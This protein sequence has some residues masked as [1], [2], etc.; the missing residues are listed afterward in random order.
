MQTTLLSTTAL[1]LLLA[2]VVLSVAATRAPQ[3]PRGQPPQG[4]AR[5]YL[6]AMIALNLMAAVLLF[7]VAFQ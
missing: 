2:G 5:H 7:V 4:R 6:L 3:P 1:V